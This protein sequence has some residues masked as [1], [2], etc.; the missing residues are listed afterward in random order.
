MTS[1]ESSAEIERQAAIWAARL[2]A[3]ALTSAEQAELD[4][5][6]AGD[7]RRLGAWAMA[8]AALARI[9]MAREEYDP[10]NALPVQ[11]P[12][13]VT[14]RRMLWGAGAAL[15]ASA[16]GAVGIGLLGRGLH[17][18]T[19]KGEMLR[20]ALSDGS[21]VNLN[22]ASGID[23]RFTAEQRTIVLRGG[24]ALFDV[25]KDP[26]RPFVVVA[27]DARV[28][29]VG[30]AFTV[31][32]ED[33]RPVDVIVSEGVVEVSQAAA[34]TPVRVS[35]GMR[36]VVDPSARAPI[37]TATIAPD[38]IEQ[39]LYWRDGKIAFRDTTLASAAA[40]FARYNDERIVIADPALAEETITGLFVANDP[41]GF[42]EAVAES[43][44]VV[45]RM[46][47]NRIILSPT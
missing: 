41:R 31:R 10:L 14:R 11:A 2:D 45:T 7:S 1:R 16:V 5:W 17:Y 13:I 38:A 35:Q 40:Q 15:A 3:R 34:A 4:H 21:I 37:E 19:G 30:T 24:E 18:M 32:H 42:A 28:R 9:E 29:A 20:I 47:G 39:E 22:T 44:G 12:A 26:E 23:V 33:S 8:R 36:A 27:G 46:E 6:L 43:L 25:A